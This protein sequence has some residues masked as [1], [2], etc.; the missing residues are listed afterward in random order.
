[1][2]GYTSVINEIGY[3]QIFNIDADP[4]EM[5][6]VAPVGGSWV[7]T[8]YFQLIGAYL[9]S[10]KTHPNPPAQNMTDFRQ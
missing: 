9:D 1:M 10:L 3:P 8:P 2:V 6:N 4:G 5:V 7:E